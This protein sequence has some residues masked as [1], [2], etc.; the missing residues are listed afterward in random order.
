MN[1]CFCGFVS[2]KRITI[3]EMQLFAVGTINRFSA[4]NN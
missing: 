2:R 1:M 3:P 4:S